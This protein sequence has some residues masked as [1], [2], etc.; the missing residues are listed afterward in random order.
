M[1]SRF[2]ATGSSESES[3]S[4]EDEILQP[5]KPASQAVKMFFSDS[6]ED[7]KR[8]VRSAKSKRFVYTYVPFMLHPSLQYNVSL[9]QLG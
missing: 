4:S 1:A 3:E 8:V 5:I 9:G 6:E 7:T 2:F